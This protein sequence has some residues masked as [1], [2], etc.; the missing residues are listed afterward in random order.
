MRPGNSVRPARPSR[1]PRERALGSRAR[2]AEWL[3]LTP[4]IVAVSAATFVMGLGE[5]L[6][7]R[8]LPKY[9]E[10]FGA[11][12]TAIG[13]FG[14]AEDFLDGVYQYP[15]GWIADRYGR[16]RALLLF[17]CL[18]AGGYALF[19][20]MTAWPAAFAALALIM[21][22]DAMASPTLFAVVGDALPRE[23]RTMG[24]T[25]QSLLRRVPIVVAPTLG[26][27]AIAR[28]GLRAGVRLGLAA[29]ILL[30]LVTL[31][32]ASRVRIP[33]VPDETPTHIGHVWRAFPP[34]L[35]WLLTSDVFIRTCEGMVD[36]FIV[37][38]AANVLGV[39]LARF[40]V[41]VAVQAATTMLVQLPAARVA[42]RTGKKPF[43]VAT[44]VAF[45]L[46]PLTVV[47]A[48]SFAALVLAFVV[49]GLREIG[50]PARKALIVDLAVP[51]LRARTVGLYYL[52]RSLAIA[53]AAFVGGLLWGVS[54]ALPFY[55]AGSIG[56]LGTLVFAR[57]VSAEHAG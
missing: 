9:L 28:L 20:G 24:F 10:S 8:F 16:R 29:S 23:K 36:V 45:S 57:T 1:A 53:P 12:I 21:A 41:L 15:G 25:V 48:R 56:L 39:S 17:V 5:N 35:R 6:W 11:P 55:V 18:A 2:A 22:W 51:S 40:G 46:F 13:L 4:E 54:P 50:E 19:A 49:G 7:R 52:C 30:A 26:G 31:A 3:G 32:V 47:W 37:L 43:V 14:T 34:V 33:V 44:F 42:Q 38:Y 27:I